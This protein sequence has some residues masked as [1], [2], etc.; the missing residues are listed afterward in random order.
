MV[1]YIDEDYYITNQ[2]DRGVPD[3]ELKRLIIEASMYIRRQTMDRIS[4]NNIPEEVK[5]ATCLIINK[6]YEFEKKKDEIGTLKSQNIEGWSETY[7]DIAL[8]KEELENDKMEILENYLS[9]IIGNDGNL[10]LSW[11]L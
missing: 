3:S 4:I 1:T 11:R 2:E 10:L 6:I 8:L 7:Q 5:R 9:E